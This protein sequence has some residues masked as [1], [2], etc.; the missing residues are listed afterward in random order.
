MLVRNEI[1]GSQALFDKI[2]WCGFEEVFVVDGNSSDGTREF[3]E[4]RGI[5][6]IVQ[7]QGGLGAAMIEARMACTTEAL[8]FFHP[9]GNEDP[10]DLLIIRAFLASGRPFVV[11]SRMIQGATNEE[12]FQRIRPR[13]WANWGLG[14]IANLLWGSSK[15]RTSDVTNGMRGLS[16]T[17]W[18]RMGLDSVDLT[19]D[20]QMIIRALKIGII[21][22]EFPTREG[23]RIA[24]ATNFKSIDTGI[25]EVK[26]IW[27][28]IRGGPPL[29]RERLRPANWLPRDLAWLVFI[30]SFLCFWSLS[31]AWI[32]GMGYTGEEMLAANDIGAKTLWML[33]VHSDPGPIHW[34][35]NGPFQVL[36]DIPFMAV[37]NL[38]PNPHA[39]QNH[40][41]AIQPCLFTAAMVMLVFVW[42]RRVQGDAAWAFLIALLTGFTTLLWPYAYIGLET[43]Q[44]FFLLLAG[45]IALEWRPVTSWPRSILFALVAAAAVASKSTGTFLIPATAF[46][47]YS[48]YCKR[49]RPLH[50]W[51]LTTVVCLV[52]AIF[53]VN[54][55]YRAFFWAAS[56]G[57]RGFLAIFAVPDPIYFFSNLVSFFGSPNKGLLFFCPSLLLALAALQVTFRTHRDLT[58]FATLI[59]LSLAGGFSLLIDWSDET[60]GPRYLHSSIA[61]LMVCLAV[62][63]SRFALRREIPL[64]ALSSIG[65][66]MA[67]FRNTL[68]IRFHAE[69]G[70]RGR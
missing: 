30:G 11:A 39:W 26:L 50:I 60:W 51:K 48:A 36:F 69:R 63:R 53:V 40:L 21:I 6:V 3:F 7:K 64:L 33:G 20:F 12:D 27:R 19:M 29:I 49:F 62:S 57:T 32:E 70:D 25:A 45:Y 61:P 22:T 13:K 8:I 35:R 52:I 47:I 18:D 17:A 42:V 16:C 9:D 43:T 59:L 46:L 56:G 1:T 66:V 5:R 67:D 34:S 14:R 65:L 54:A 15:N 31:P 38:C 68:P 37:A 2:P 10:D 23:S 4:Q 41:V 28:E 58:I 55:H 44:S 24:G